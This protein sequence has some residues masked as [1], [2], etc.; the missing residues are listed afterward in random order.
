MKKFVIFLFACF[1]TFPLL[2]QGRGT[3]SILSI[4][5]NIIDR[6]TDKELFIGDKVDLQTEFRFGDTY[7]EA[8]LLS[9]SKVKYWLKMPESMFA[10]QQ[11]VVSSQQALQTV[12][13]RPIPMSG[14]RGGA[15]VKLASEGVSLETLKEYFG[16]DT[17]SV[18][19]PSLQLPVT[20]ADLAQYRL[21]VRYEKNGVTDI[22]ADNFTLSKSTLTDGDQSQIKECYLLLD[23]GTT[24]QPVTQICLLFVDEERLLKEFSAYLAALNA[25]KTNT[26]RTRKLLQQYCVDIY[27]NI[28]Q[29]NLEKTINKFFGK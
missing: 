10:A 8:V 15:A 2:A 20:A 27:G 21:V 16:V 9:P 1:C 6:K 24:M 25:R 13:S 12:R 18:I 4:K 5:G 28:D 3:Y 22:K 17:F 19:G 26:A 29:S 14:T 23:N 7:D 11:L